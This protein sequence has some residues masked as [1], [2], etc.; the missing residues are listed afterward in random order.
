MSRSGSKVFSVFVVVVI[1]AI[2]NSIPTVH[3]QELPVVLNG[4]DLAGW[5]IPEGNIWFA[6]KDGVLDVK[7][8]P[9]QKGAILW[10][11]KDYSDFVMQFE[12]KMGEGTVDTGIFIRNE[13]DQIQIGISGSL[14]RDMTA[15]P[16][17]ARKGYPVEAEGVRELLRV[18]GWNKMLIVAVGGYY[19][20]W[21]NGKPVMSYT[22]ETASESGPIGIQLHAKKQMSC[23]YRNIRLA[24]LP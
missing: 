13:V 16:Y 20:V 11:E 7:S 5:K 23:T 15:S 8:G 21:L 6:A 22:S 4:N 24:E 17:V 10:T 3:G 14:K 12:F 9:K 1:A 19:K 2:A 18:D